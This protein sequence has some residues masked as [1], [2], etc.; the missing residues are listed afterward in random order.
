MSFMY[1]E[2]RHVDRADRGGI[3]D[4]G[5][6]VTV[7]NDGACNWLGGENSRSSNTPFAVYQIAKF[8]G[9]ECISDDN[10]WD[11]LES[12][13]ARYGTLERQFVSDASTKTLLDEL[14]RRLG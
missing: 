7:K 1:L 8:D 11:E 6:H 3:F 5:V 4:G 9:L 13:P 10:L 2:L 12:R 14:A